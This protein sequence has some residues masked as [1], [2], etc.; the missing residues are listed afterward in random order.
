M[1]LFEIKERC[2]VASALFSWLLIYNNVLI[3]NEREN[4]KIKAVHFKKF[5]ELMM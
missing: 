3:K 2:S 5:I 1:I 4:N